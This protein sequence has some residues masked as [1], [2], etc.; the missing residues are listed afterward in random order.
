MV[1]VTFTQPPQWQQHEGIYPMQTIMA[2]AEMA[3][4]SC[5]T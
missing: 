5:P 2:I 3:T 4:P 1:N